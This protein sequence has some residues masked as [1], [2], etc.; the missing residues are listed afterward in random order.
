MLGLMRRGVCGVVCAVSMVLGASGGVA[1]GSGG[2]DGGAARDEGKRSVF[3]DG[4]HDAAFDAAG[5][6]KVLVLYFTATWCG[7][8]RQMERTVWSDA[9][10]IERLTSDAVVCKIDIDRH[11]DLARQYGIR[12]VP[13]MV[14]FKGG[15]PFGRITGGRSKDALL[16]WVDAVRAAER[17]E[18]V[19]DGRRAPRDGEA[20]KGAEGGSASERFQRARA[21]MHEG[22][23]AEA[24]EQFIWLWDEGAKAG[25][26]FVGVRLSFM[27]SEIET[28]CAEHEPARAAFAARR[29]ALG[30]TLEKRALDRTVVMD[31]VA[32][33][34]ALGD[35]ARTLAWWDSI[36]DAESKVRVG[37][38]VSLTLLPV[39]YEAGR[40]ADAGRV[41]RDPVPAAEVRI[42]G[43]MEGVA[44]AR[45][46]GLAEERLAAVID[47]LA[48]D[49]ANEH[50]ALLAAGREGEGMRIAM[51]AVTHIKDPARAPLVRTALKA[52]VVRPVHR[53]LL[54]G[55]GGARPDDYEALVAR[56]EAALAARE[57]R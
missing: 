1:L 12:A 19:G 53:D 57:Q 46:A 30:A 36:V 9:E 34:E 2:G 7:P 43:R 10:V 11:G 41:L 32:L 27:I 24:L 44:E 8:C 51:L 29:D 38:T 16:G 56:V 23:H 49:C 40:W 37:Q 35:G 39:L 31:F 15:K 54:A 13:T 17:P 21:L 48:K 42:A 22:K 33:N 52:G 28:L 47:G 55:M 45:E 5:D 25:P 4:G 3:F 50:A 26:A 18:D 14:S 20:K 6:G